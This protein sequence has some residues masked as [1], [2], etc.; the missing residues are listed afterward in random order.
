VYFDEEPKTSREDLYDFDEQYQRLLKLLKEG[1]RFIAVKGLRRTGK[2]SLCL[3]CLREARIPYLFVDCRRFA[4]MPAITRVDLTR[5]LEDATND[6]LKRE[7]GLARRM[8]DWLKGVRGV[9]IRLN[10]PSVTLSW[11]PRAEAFDPASLFESLSNLAG[12]RGERFVLVLDEAQELKRL[13]DYDLRRILAYAFDHLRGLQIVVTGS[14]VGFLHD[15]LKMDDPE[16]P[17]YGRLVCEVSLPHLSESQA[18]EFLELGF[19]Q[20][21]IKPDRALLEE[22]VRKLDGVIGWLTYLGARAREKG[23]FDSSVLEEAIQRGSRLA[24]KE[25]ENFLAIHPAKKRYMLLARR[26]SQPGGA[27]WS[28][29]K[30]T[31]EA[32]E[33]KKISNK[34]VTEL[35]NNLVKGGFFVKEGERYRI[36]DP[37]LAAAFS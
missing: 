34:R 24:A 6:F 27:T 23:Y 1:R 15:F 16:S 14:Q 32:S 17:L 35:I 9:S 30:K 5:L 12:E 25:F 10:P 8:L 4:Q 11:G 22:S 21:G 13:V 37:L 2:T 33:G 29:L 7:A 18:L 31:L 20:I 28:E 36:A 26:G 3:T 19:K